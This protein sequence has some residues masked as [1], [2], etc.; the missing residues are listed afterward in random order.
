MP[1]SS[2]LRLSPRRELIKE[3]AHGRSHSL[4]NGLDARDKDDKLALFDEINK[5]DREK[6]L[7]HFS[8]DFDGLIDSKVE[9]A[10]Q[11]RGGNCNLLNINGDNN[12]Y[13]WLVAPPESPLFR[14][15]DDDQSRASQERRREQ[16]NGKI[17]MPTRSNASP[18]RQIR[19]PRSSYDVIQTAARPSSAPH[20]ISTPV[21]SEKTPLKRPSTPPTKRSPPSPRSSSPT[22]QR[23]SI[24]AYGQT[25]SS[26]TRGT[27][28]IKAS[29]QNFA[30]PTPR[31]RRSS[32]SGFS[33]ETPPNLRTFMPDQSGSRVRGT[34][35]VS[36]VSMSPSSKFGTRSTPPSPARN[37]ISSQSHERQQSHCRESATS[38]GHDDADSIFC[39]GIGLSGGSTRKTGSAEKSRD[40]PS[41]K[42]TFILPSSFS[43]TT[44]SFSYVVRDNSIFLTY[45]CFVNMSIK[46]N[47]ICKG[48][49]FCS[50]DE[51]LG[52]VVM[53][54]DHQET[55]HG[56]SSLLSGASAAKLCDG[57]TNNKVHGSM[58]SGKLSH[59]GR[60][61]SNSEGDLCFSHNMEYGSHTRN[62]LFDEW[63]I[64]KQYGIQEAEAPNFDNIDKLSLDYHHGNS[65]QTRDFYVGS[66]T[67][68]VDLQKFQSSAGGIRDAVNTVSNFQSSYVAGCFKTNTSGV[69]IT[70]LTC[71]KHTH[72]MDLDGNNDFFQECATTGELLNFREQGETGKNSP[73]RKAPIETIVTSAPGKPR[74]IKDEGDN[75]NS[76]HDKSVESANS[77][78]ETSRVLTELSTHSNSGS[79]KG[80][81]IGESKVVRHE[82]ANEGS[83]SVDDCQ[84][85]LHAAPTYYSDA[86]SEKKIDTFSEDPQ[87]LHSQPKI[88]NGVDNSQECS[89]LMK[90][91][92]AN[93][94]SIE[95]YNCAE[96]ATSKQGI[97]LKAQ[98]SGERLF[99]LEEATESILFCSS[100]IHDLAYKAATIE[101]EKEMVLSKASQP[102]FTHVEQSTQDEKDLQT[103]SN[104]HIKISQSD[105]RKK[106][107]TDKDFGSGAKIYKLV[108][109]ATIISPRKC[110]C[111]VM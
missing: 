1:P 60:Y 47:S 51:V 45:P 66:R 21:V 99:T 3:S 104:I 61:N 34:S 109:S 8:N 81:D 4:N 20:S 89:L 108:S 22:V 59:T 67:S 68:E 100:I 79:E 43:G 55:S 102:T 12:D 56:M 16:L 9:I 82:N 42:K 90:S 96:N 28:P 101:M 25:V 70:N 107:E 106:M 30:S 74:G 86:I 27:S 63:E 71:G 40:V 23:I 53:H 13:D 78:L 26:S 105:A 41:Y 87:N 98:R 83:N 38:F 64:T 19:S 93:S 32:F 75:I 80:V 84:V 77:C 111:I 110:N 36:G 91:D 73:G 92:K 52:F 72:K 31:G 58:L 103:L 49:I 18:S 65:T 76:S 54:H 2:P 46:E 44:E 14:S 62:H 17:Q 33:M 48:N 15:L 50:T 69:S 97:S 29:H 5:H 57:K 10:I 37:C 88:P 94:A 85:V 6:L 35:P 39:S 11:P 7:V 95:E 24:G